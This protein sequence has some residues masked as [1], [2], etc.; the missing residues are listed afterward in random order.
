MIADAVKEAYNYV[1]MHINYLLIRK[2]I[3]ALK[4]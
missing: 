1:S 3:F 4:A 2:G